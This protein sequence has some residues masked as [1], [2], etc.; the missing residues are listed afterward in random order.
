MLGGARALLLYAVED[1][2]EGANGLVV[3]VA[4]S[5]GWR[6][7]G[8]VAMKGEMNDWVAALEGE[9]LQSL[10]EVGPLTPQGSTRALFAVEEVES[11]A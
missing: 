6:H 2:E 8:V 5:P 7:G 10:V 1:R 9:G 3:S 11:D 4:L